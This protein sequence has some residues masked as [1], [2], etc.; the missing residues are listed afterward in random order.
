M[1]QLSDCQLLSEHTALLPTDIIY[2]GLYCVV[3]VGC[4]TCCSIVLPDYTVSQPGDE[5]DCCQIRFL[6]S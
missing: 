2:E 6:F 1:C 5:V 4:G 3:V